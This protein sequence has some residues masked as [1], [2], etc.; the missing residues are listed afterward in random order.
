MYRFSSGFACTPYGCA[1]PF[2]GGTFTNYAGTP[3]A[4]C[5]DIARDDDGIPRAQCVPELFLQP[6]IF[7]YHHK[8]IGKIFRKIS[9]K[10]FLVP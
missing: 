8:A 3:A 9:N 6:G 10:N 7:F 5:L 1:T 2:T 4:V